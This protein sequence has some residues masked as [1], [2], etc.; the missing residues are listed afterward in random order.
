[1]HWPS[2]SVVHGG[3]EGS[4]LAVQNGLPHE[5]GVD[6]GSAI[7]E[8]EVESSVQEVVSTPTFEVIVSIAPRRLFGPSSPKNVSGSNP[9]ASRSMLTSVSLPK[10]V[11]TPVARSAVSA[12]VAR[13]EPEH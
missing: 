6:L 5:A 11:A 8:I 7:E 4:H 10:P 13:D 2:D 3:C 9:P 1:M 12:G